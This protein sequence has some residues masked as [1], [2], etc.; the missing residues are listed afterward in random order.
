MLS[1]RFGRSTGFPYC[2]R[3]Q[4][5]AAAVTDK[6]IRQLYDRMIR[7]DHAG[8]SA[9]NRIYAGQMAVLGNTKSGPVIKHMWE[10]EKVHLAKFEELIGRHR[11]R[12]TVMLPIWSVVS[13]LLGAGTAALGKEAAMAC[14]VAVEDTI[15]KHYDNQIRTLMQECGEATD[16]K[17]LLDII[18]K[19]RDEEMEH[20][21]TGLVH[22]AKKA[23]V[24]EALTEVI[25]MGCLGAI[26]ISERI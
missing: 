16:H 25:K 24:Y 8:E 12:P 18:K 1:V 11:V 14:T 21:D 5:T 13:Y 9:A 4:S 6:R 22:D 17:E 15:V 19:F 3:M 20:H 10:Q 2:R 7:V 23:P 26:W